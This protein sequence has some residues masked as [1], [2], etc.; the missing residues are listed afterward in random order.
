MLKRLKAYFIYQLQKSLKPQI[1]GGFKN[2]RSGNPDGV[3]ISNTT[4]ISYPAQ[5]NLESHVFIG[6]FN[7]IDCQVETRIGEGTQV[8]NYVSILN[9]SSHHTI[10]MFGKSYAEKYSSFK[11]NTGSVDIGKYCFI[12]PHSVIMPET[13]IGKGC[14]V[15]AYS[16]VKG[17]FPDYS[18]LK[19][20]P[21]VIVGD[22]RKIDAELLERHPELR[23]FYY[24]NS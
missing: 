18:I 13:K 11:E 6:H 5:L 24:L 20:N 19:G 4:H 9:H 21:A 12:G 14:I 8:T 22:T 3:R 16:L 17:E 10:R 23:E 2:Q 7:Y 15:S 1:I